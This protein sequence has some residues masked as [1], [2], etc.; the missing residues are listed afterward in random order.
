MKFFVPYAKPGSDEEAW[1]AI[2]KNMADRL[3]KTT[4]RRIFRLWYTH[5]G[6]A[7]VAEVGKDH[8]E[9]RETVFAIFDTVGPCYLVCTTNRGAMQGGPLLVG[10][11]ETESVEEFNNE[12]EPPSYQQDFGS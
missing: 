5:N 12:G 2:R 7:I 9:E 4:D 10:R 1:Q 3:G 6:R 11:P 8:A